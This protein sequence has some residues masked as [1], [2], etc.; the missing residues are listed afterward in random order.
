MLAFSRHSKTASHDNRDPGEIQ[1]D[2][3]GLRLSYPPD[4]WQMCSFVIQK[5]VDSIFIRPV[6]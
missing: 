2:A 4:T 5:K 3:H 1:L 6:L